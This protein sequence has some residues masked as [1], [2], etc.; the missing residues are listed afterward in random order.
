M[1]NYYEPYYLIS[2]GALSSWYHHG[3]ASHR[4]RTPQIRE[5]NRPCL[6][7]GKPFSS[8]KL[9]CS[10]ECFVVYKHERVKK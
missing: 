10:R 8:A 4:D 1:I 2:S 5:K 6:V 7:C 3:P 9:C